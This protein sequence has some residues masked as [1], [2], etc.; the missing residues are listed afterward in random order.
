MVKYTQTICW[1]FADE[2]FECVW[3]FGE[4]SAPKGQKSFLFPQKFLVLIKKNQKE[5]LIQW[6]QEFKHHIGIS[7]K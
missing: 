6:S 5:G 1:Q 4:V 7:E 3:S 2:L